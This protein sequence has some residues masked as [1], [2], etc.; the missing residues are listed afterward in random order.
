MAEAQYNIATMY[1]AG[2]GVTKDERKAYMYFLLAVDA[3]FPQ[4][5]NKELEK[6]SK[7][8]EVRKT[9]SRRHFSP[10]ISSRS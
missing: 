3:G 8:D 9:S 6:L 10:V 1:E 2:E 5:A 7:H 4:F